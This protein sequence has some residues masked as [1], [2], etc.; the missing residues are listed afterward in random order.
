[1]ALLYLQ[2]IVMTPKSLSFNDVG[3]RASLDREDIASFAQQPF[4]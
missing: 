3:E 1:M 2:K 4:G